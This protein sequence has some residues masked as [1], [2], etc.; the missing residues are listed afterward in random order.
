MN[1]LLLIPRADMLIRMEE[2]L[3]DMQEIAELLDS[4]KMLKDIDNL[5]LEIAALMAEDEDATE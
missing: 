3:D 4:E 2:M 5:R 1:N